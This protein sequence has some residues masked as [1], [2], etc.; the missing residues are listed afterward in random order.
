M[1]DR[2][3]LKLLRR[4]S[5]FL[6]ICLVAILFSGCTTRE[7]RVEKLPTS[8]FTVTH[9]GHKYVVYREEMGYAGAGGITHSA[10]CSANHNN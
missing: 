5:L 7:E 1:N 4:L 3:T 9:E 2:L 6:V 10:S 8:V